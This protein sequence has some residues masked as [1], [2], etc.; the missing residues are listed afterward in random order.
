[1]WCLS[2]YT[3]CAEEPKR[4]DVAYGRVVLAAQ[5]DA[6]RREHAPVDPGPCPQHRPERKDRA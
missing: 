4:R 3:L 2:R 5:V 1:M 6:W